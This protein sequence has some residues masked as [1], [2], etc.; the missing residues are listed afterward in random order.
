MKQLGFTKYHLHRLLGIPLED[1]RIMRNDLSVQISGKTVAT[2]TNGDI[3]FDGKGSEVKVAV[4]QSMREW[5]AK[6]SAKN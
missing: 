3:K 5:D 1:I 4:G 2:I 6:S